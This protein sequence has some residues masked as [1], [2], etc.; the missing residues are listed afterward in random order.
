MN[1]KKCGSPINGGASFCPVCG[2]PVES[3]V[4]ADTAD[5]VA[6]SADTAA[7]SADTAA[8]SVSEERSGQNSYIQQAFEQEQI[9]Q[10]NPG[11]KHKKPIIIASC[12]AVFLILCVFTAKTYFARDLTQFFMGE[13]KYMQSAEGK[14][15]SSLID[16]NI[17]VLDSATHT[18]SSKVSDHSLS[19]KSTFSVALS[20]KINNQI[21]QESGDSGLNSLNKVLDFINTLSITSDSNYNGGKSQSNISILHNTNKLFSVNYFSGEDENQIFQIPEISKTYLVYDASAVTNPFNVK[22]DSNKL[23]ASLSALTQVYIDKISEGKTSVQKDQSLTVDGISVNAEKLSVTLNEKQITEILKKTIQT[24]KSDEYL[25]TFISENYAE[26]S[27]N[28]SK[29]KDSSDSSIPEKLEKSDYQKSCDELISDL[30]SDGAPFSLTIS[31]YI[32][33]NNTQVARTYEI[34]RTGTSG[35][36]ANKFNLKNT[37]GQSPKKIVFNVAFPKKDGLEQFGANMKMD[38]Y[39]FFSASLLHSSSSNGT[40][41]ILFKAPDTGTGGGLKLDFSNLNKV[42]FA[43]NDAYTGTFKMSFLDSDG[44]FGDTTASDS[45]TTSTVIS[46]LLKSKFTVTSSVTGE[47]L[48][49]NVAADVNDTVSVKFNSVLT[50]SK[51]SGTITVPSIDDSKSIFLSNKGTDSNYLNQSALKQQYQSDIMA[52]LFTLPSKDSDIADLISSFHSSGTG[53]IE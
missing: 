16:R 41:K 25:Y 13:N 51:S 10:N 6:S 23:K 35:D 52:Y 40:V 29:Y 9:Q 17:T 1:C 46:N 7:S 48:S 27:K 20:D 22:Y 43:G 8:D 19:S 28:L 18:I 45:N 34:T 50:S 32:M 36:S 37:T 44:K 49:I 39:E 2:E 5:T 4:N 53:G 3:T 21:K 11:K 15:T 31:A 12:I 30:G 26:F 38:G 24:A 42:K 47:K 33:P 14:I